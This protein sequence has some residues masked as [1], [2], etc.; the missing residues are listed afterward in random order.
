MLIVNILQVRNFA[1]NH[2]R[3]TELRYKSGANAV[4]GT[5]FDWHI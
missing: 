2:C 4:E 3:L 5:E 1:K